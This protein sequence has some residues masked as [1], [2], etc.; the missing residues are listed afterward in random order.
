MNVIK[1][2]TVVS[3]SKRMKYSE[4]AFAKNFVDGGVKKLLLIGIVEQVKE[5]YHNLECVLNLI[6]LDRIDF[7]CAFDLKLA[8]A[9]L[10][11]GT[12]SSTFPCPWCEVPKSSFSDPERVIEMRTLGSIRDNATMYQ[13]ALVNHNRKT[14]LSAADFKSCQNVPLLKNLPNDTV[15]L[16]VIPVMELHLVLGIVNR[17]YDHL[18]A[19]FRGIEGCDLRAIDWSDKLC[20][21]RPPQ[22]GGEFNGEQCKKL[23]QSVHIL[24][25]LIESDGTCESINK[26][27]QTFKMFEDVRQKCFSMKLLPEYDQSIRAFE[28]TYKDLNIPVTS[29]AHAIFDHVEAFIDRQGRE[30]GLGYFSEQASESVHA[31]FS[32]MW[33]RYKR[34]I[35]HSEY[36]TKL[37]ACVVAYSPRHR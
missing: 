27:V 23:L 17:L 28:S 29:K 37:L 30:K 18:D 13:A 35:E 11:I 5:T 14:K 34:E 32:L 36:G 8:N 26:I 24:E 12:H 4:G 1:E 2:D 16:D 19:T 7:V 3:D 21:K 31:D 9:F 10:G 6:G 15:V 22:H 20:I 33:R 25:R